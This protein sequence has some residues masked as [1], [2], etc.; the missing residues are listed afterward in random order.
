[1]S[2]EPRSEIVQDLENSREDLHSAVAGLPEAH[3]KVTPEPGRWSVLEC[4]EHIVNAEDRWLNRLKEAETTGAPPID[5]EK[6]ARLR[7]RIND[8]S[9]RAQAPEPV[10]PVGRFA[11]LSQALEAFNATRTRTMQFA[12]E[13]GERLYSINTQHPAF[14]PMNGTELLVIAANHCRRHSAQIREVRA[15]IEKS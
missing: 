12:Q 1:M 7:V 4:L 6:E 2:P 13:Q 8:R 11:T 3:S 14:G 15:A 10:R 9:F 5:K